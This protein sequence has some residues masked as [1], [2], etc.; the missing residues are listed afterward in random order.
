MFHIGPFTLAPRYILDIK[1]EIV[2]LPHVV[3]FTWSKQAIFI[4]Y[5]S[6]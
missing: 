1:K 5:I 4:C 3:Q 2:T 6:S